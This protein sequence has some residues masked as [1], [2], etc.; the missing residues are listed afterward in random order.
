MAA[1]HLAEVLQREVGAERCG[2]KIIYA[3]EP[4]RL[5]TGGAIK[6]AW[7]NYM[8]DNGESTYVLN[9]DILSAVDYSEMV[10]YLN[11]ES[12][13]IILGAKV[14]DASTYGVLDFDENYHLKKFN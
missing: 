5:G 3:I 7:D 14:D 2:L 13:G 1:G 9:G 11:P 10:K 8:P 12:D 6:F 4:Q